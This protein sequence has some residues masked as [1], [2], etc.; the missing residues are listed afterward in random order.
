MGAWWNSLEKVS[1]VNTWILGSAALFG[2]LAAILVIAGWFL[3]NRASDL[4]RAQLAAFRADADAKIAAADQIAAQANEHAKQLEA[5]T[6][7]LR[8]ENLEIQRRISPRFLTARE[9]DVI[10]DGIRPFRGH[11]IILTRLGDGEAGPY[12]DSIIAVFQQAEW[13]VQVR[14]VGV[15]VPPTYGI[16]CRVSPRTDSAVKALIGSFHKANIGIEVQEVPA[17]PQDS[18]VDIMVA[19]KPIS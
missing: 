9:R 14:S 16:I 15:F 5:D 8:N 3:G 19:L 4:E 13:D 7:K 6:E 10:F 11:Q 17:A 1:N 18:W 2:F 12:G